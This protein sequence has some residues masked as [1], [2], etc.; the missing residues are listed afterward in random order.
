MI[1]LTKTCLWQIRIVFII[2]S[3]HFTHYADTLHTCGRNNKCRCWWAR[4]FILLKESR[5][6]KVLSLLLQ[7]WLNFFIYFFKCLQDFTRSTNDSIFNRLYP[8]LLTIS[9]G[10]R[11]KGNRWT[12]LKLNF[13]S[14]KNI[15]ALVIFISDLLIIT[16]RSSSRLFQG[17]LGSIAI[18]SWKKR[19]RQRRQ[20]V[21]FYIIWKKVC[22]CKTIFN[23]I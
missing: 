3:H 18:S 16:L 13:N 20:M 23:K 1:M 8:L 7:L 6:W 21:P 4:K 9:T 5:P 17:Q 15:S 11:G 2:Y 19:D 12:F 10:P 14:T 22:Y